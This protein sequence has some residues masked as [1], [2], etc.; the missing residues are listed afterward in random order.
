[1][2]VINLTPHPVTL[3]SADTPD[4]TDDPS[5]GVLA[6]WEAAGPTARH[7]ETRRPAGSIALHTPGGEVVHA[8]LSEVGFGEVTGLPNPTDEVT[9]IV[10]RATAERATGRLDVV[11]Q[12][13]P[14]RSTSGQIVGCRALARAATQTLPDTYRFQHKDPRRVLGGKRWEDY[15]VGQ[16]VTVLSPDIASQFGTVVV[17]VG[18]ALAHLR[19]EVARQLHE[20]LGYARRRAGRQQCP[21]CPEFGEPIAGRWP[22]WQCPAGHTFDVEMELSR[23]RPCTECH[24]Y[25]NL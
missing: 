2:H 25:G 1:M 19:G 4:V 5:V 20:A 17:R 16:F 3:Y 15:T 14:V 6:V 12:D 13:R 24:G 23:I 18:T 22:M 21:E 8:P 11:Y 7:T 10:S 9:Y